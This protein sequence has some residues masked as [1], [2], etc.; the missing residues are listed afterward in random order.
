MDKNKSGESDPIDDVYKKLTIS[1]ERRLKEHAM[2]LDFSSWMDTKETFRRIR[3]YRAI[4]DRLRL[5]KAGKLLNKV[6]KSYKDKKSGG[7]SYSVVNWLKVLLYLLPKEIREG[8]FGDL[9]EVRSQMRKE[10]YGQISI[11][12]ILIGKGLIL[13]YAAVWIKLTDFIDKARSTQK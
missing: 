13:A 6:R 1:L 2:Y 8:S 11:S 4:K 5:A 3:E 9:M 7:L 12:L 10:K